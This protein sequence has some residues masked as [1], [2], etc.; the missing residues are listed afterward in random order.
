MVDVAE[1]LRSECFPEI[2]DWTLDYDEFRYRVDWW[3]LSMRY[4]LVFSPVAYRI[5]WYGLKVAIMLSMLGCALWFSE[6]FFA[7][8]LIFLWFSFV[9]GWKLYKDAKDWEFHKGRNLY[10][11]WLRKF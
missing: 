6:K 10:D 11:L 4:Y 2:G 3:N 8:S 1:Y 9:A 5:G 7:V